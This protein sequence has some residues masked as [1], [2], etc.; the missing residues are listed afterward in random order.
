MLQLFKNTAGQYCTRG[1]QHVCKLCLAHR[2]QCIMSDL[3]TLP[4]DPWMADCSH[5][6]QICTS[7]EVDELLAEIQKAQNLLGHVQALHHSTPWDE[8]T[9]MMREVGDA[10]EDSGTSSQRLSAG[11][12]LFSFLTCLSE[13]W[14]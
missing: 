7:R 12:T 6:P 9:C 10:K 5:H 2:P 3:K 8:L 13:A 14:L 4:S 1:T 11:L